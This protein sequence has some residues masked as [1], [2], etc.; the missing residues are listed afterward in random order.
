MAGQAIIGFATPDCYTSNTSRGPCLA[1]V[2]DLPGCGFAVP[3]R[4]RLPSA[5]PIPDKGLV[6]LTKSTSCEPEAAIC[7]TNVVHN[8]RQTIQGAARAKPSGTGRPEPSSRSPSWSRRPPGLIVRGRIL[9]LRLRA[10]RSL[11]ATVGRTHVWKPSGNH[12]PPPRPWPAVGPPEH[13]LPMPEPETP[14]ECGPRHP[15]AGECAAGPERRSSALAGGSLAGYR[16]AKG[17]RSWRTS[18]RGN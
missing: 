1:Q 6:S 8:R 9:Y 4:V 7:C 12:A 18:R 17:G 13:V 14:R 3:W 5:P 2:I 16:L 10:P 11:E 15:P